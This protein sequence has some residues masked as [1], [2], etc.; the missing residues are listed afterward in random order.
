MIPNAMG[1]SG[2]IWSVVQLALCALIAYFSLSSLVT[3]ILSK[4]DSSFQLDPCC[5][6]FQSLLIPKTCW[7]L[8][9]KKIQKLCQRFFLPYLLECCPCYLGFG[10]PQPEHLLYLSKISEFFSKIFETDGLPIDKYW[11]LIIAVTISSQPFS[12]L[13]DFLGLSFVPC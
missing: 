1:P 5:F 9:W 6:W 10:N 3:F 11:N 2:I 12:N 8:I 7:N 13:L 4:N